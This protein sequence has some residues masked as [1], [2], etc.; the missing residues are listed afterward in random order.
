MFT[1]KPG[2]IFPLSFDA[3][4]GGVMFDGNSL[5]ACIHWTYATLFT[6]PFASIA[7]RG[8]VISLEYVEEIAMRMLAT[9]MHVPAVLPCALIH[10]LRKAW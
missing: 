4:D 10:L 5:S 9:F 3:S 6:C 7:D 1:D 2:R 8:M